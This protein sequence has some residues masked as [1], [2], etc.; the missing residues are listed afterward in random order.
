[1]Y[2]LHH[3]SYTVKHPDTDRSIGTKIE[4]TGWARVILVQENTATVRV[5]QACIDISSATT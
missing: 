1:M 4:T 2:S 5:E 3:V